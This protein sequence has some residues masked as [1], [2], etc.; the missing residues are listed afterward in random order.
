MPTKVTAASQLATIKPITES[1]CEF[2]YL[3]FGA[4]PQDDKTTAEVVS[5]Q[6][7]LLSRPRVVLTSSS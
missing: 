1:R 2:P 6:K 7:M 3:T 4:E 5:I